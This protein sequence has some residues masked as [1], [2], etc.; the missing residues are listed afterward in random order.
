M[1]NIIDVGERLIEIDLLKTCIFKRILS[2]SISPSKRMTRWMDISE[3]N[4]RTAPGR[5][6]RGIFF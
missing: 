3:R 4:I 1:Q 6:E 2:A 5:K